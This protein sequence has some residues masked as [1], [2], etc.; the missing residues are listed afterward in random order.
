M[1]IIFKKDLADASKRMIDGCEDE[2]SIY[3][4]PDI[5]YK[6]VVS[7]LRSTGIDFSLDLPHLGELLCQAGYAV[8]T[9]NGANKKTYYA[10]LSV[11]NGKKVSFLKIPKSVIAEFQEKIGLAE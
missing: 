4:I 1:Y 2:N 9:S 6:N 3:L 5:A 7:W 10:R 8:T 11:G